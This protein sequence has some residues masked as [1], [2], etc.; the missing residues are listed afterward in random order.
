[1]DLIIGGVDI[2][3]EALGGLSQTYAPLGGSQIKRLL[4]GSAVKIT[5]WQKTQI[6]TVGAGAMPAG[7]DGLDYT[8]ALQ[9]SCVAPMSIGGTASGLSVPPRYTARQ[10]AGYAPAEWARLD[11]GLWVPSSDSRA[12]G[13]SLFRLYFYPILQVLAD[14]PTEV[15]HIDGSRQWTLTAQEV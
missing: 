5:L 10:D 4:S 13:A 15:E 9:M 11:S 6:T 2:P 12:S 7:L 14:P 3:K 1:M 8:Q